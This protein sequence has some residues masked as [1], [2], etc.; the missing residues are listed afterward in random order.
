MNALHKYYSFFVAFFLTCF[1]ITATGA[2]VSVQ[3]NRILLGDIVKN[4]ETT[5]CEIDLGSSPLPG[6]S[7]TVTKNAILNAARRASQNLTDLDI[8]QRIVVTRQKSNV[9]HK[10]VDAKVRSA[11]EAILPNGTVIESLGTIGSISLPITDYELRAKWPGDNGFKR[12]VSIPVEFVV[13][14][15]VFRTVRVAAT[16]TFE[17]EVWAASRELQRGQVISIND[18]KLIKI[19]GEGLGRGMFENQQDVIGQKVT[20]T[21]LEGT[22]LLE[23]DVEKPPVVKQ[24]GRIV[25]ESRIGLITIRASGTARQDGAIGQ[26]IRVS[27]DSSNSLVTAEVASPGFAVVI[28]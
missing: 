21:I 17:T 12:R 20:R 16:L 24:G 22:P 1:S 5:L 28:Q 9:S 3:G 19:H 10:A 23:R 6:K 27:V 7:I 26:R 2:T 18:V 25:I 14:N 4:C 13:N 11:V 15:K 8:P